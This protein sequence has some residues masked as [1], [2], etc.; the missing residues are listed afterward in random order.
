MVS[1]SVPLNHLVGKTKPDVSLFVVHHGPGYAWLLAKRLGLV[2][3]GAVR[4]TIGSAAGGGNPRVVITI[5]RDERYG[6][7][8]FLWV[9]EGNP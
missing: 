4:E 5:G 2:T 8:V 3:P 7:Q 1:G 6:V 9:M